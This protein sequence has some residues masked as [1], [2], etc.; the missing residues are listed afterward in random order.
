VA[1]NTGQKD[2]VAT[3]C[4]YPLARQTPVTPLYG[5]GVDGWG[6]CDVEEI[7]EALEQVWSDREAAR[8][9]GAAGAAAMAQWSWRNQIGRLHD[10]LKPLAA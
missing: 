1:D 6:E 4:V 2:L 7:V 5:E 10:V 3:G 9:R 8:Q